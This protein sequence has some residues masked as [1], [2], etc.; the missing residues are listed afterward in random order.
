M[1]SREFV[2]GLVAEMRA[3]FARLGEQ[4]ALEAE[5]QGSVDVV[6]LLGLALR[7]ELEAAELAGFWMATTPEIDARLVFGRQC[8]DEMQHYQLICDRLRELGREPEADPL[9]AGFS[10]L[11]HY[12][13]GLRST[14]ERMAAGPFAREAI[15]EVRNEQ[16]IA[17][18]ERLG[19]GATARLYREVIQP[20]EILHHRLGREFLERHCTTPAAQEAAAAAARA[21]LAIADE[22]SALAEKSTGMRTIPVS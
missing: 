15:A 4:G 8:G 21:T 22:L 5:A 13:K 16:F 11:Y 3:L 1:E 19:D 20:E 10:P 17:L 7:S 2:A 18:C 9:A 12:V 14:V 6:T